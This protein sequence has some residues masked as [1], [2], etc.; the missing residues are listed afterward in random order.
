MEVGAKTVDIPCPGTF[1]PNMPGTPA[2]NKLYLF[3]KQRKYDCHMWGRRHCKGK[4][5]K[6]V[7]FMLLLL[8]PIC[9]DD[10]FE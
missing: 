6:R 1:A 2:R 7:F 8:M 9:L 5:N 10:K 4:Y 3:L